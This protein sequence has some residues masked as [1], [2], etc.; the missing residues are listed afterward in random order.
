[1]SDII[2]R[3]I[4]LFTWFNRIGISFLVFVLALSAYWYFEPDPLRVTYVE[5]RGTIE[6][7]QCTNR[8]Y[9][10]HRRVVALKDV[11]V[12]VQERYSSL[13]FPEYNGIPHLHVES[14]TLVYFTPKGTDVVMSFIK[15]VPNVLPFGTY[16]Y[17]P[18]ATYKVNPIKT[19]TKPLPP[20]RIE[21]ICD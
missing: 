10:M 5:D 21:V 11:D 13:D 3:Q 9:H 15:E 20:Q 18:L 7:S 16:E 12:V 1:M 8:E 17:K 2:H 14:K 4:M 6:W 19:I